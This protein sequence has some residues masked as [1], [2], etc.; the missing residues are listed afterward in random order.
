MKITKRQ[1]TKT[2]YPEIKENEQMNFMHEILIWI[3]TLNNGAPM[4]I[5]AYKIQLLFFFYS[6]TIIDTLT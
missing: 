4:F 5:G 2:I 6:S 1:I 3:K